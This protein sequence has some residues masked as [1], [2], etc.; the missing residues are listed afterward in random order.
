MLRQIAARDLFRAGVAF[1]AL[2]IAA[3]PAHAQSAGDVAEPLTAGQIEDII[4]TARRVSESAQKTPLSV[5]AISSQQLQTPQPLPKDATG[6][7]AM[8]DSM[9][10]TRIDPEITRAGRHSP[11][12]SPVD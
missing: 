8:V 9:Q 6:G 1:G 12:G 11:I 3:A 2:L 4:V 10:L 5:S 7:R